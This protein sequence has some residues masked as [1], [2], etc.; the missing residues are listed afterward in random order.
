M[1]LLETSL[2]FLLEGTYWHI[3]FMLTKQNCLRL[4]QMWDTQSIPASET[5]MSI[6]VILMVLVA[7]S[8][9]AGYQL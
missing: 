8:L 2:P 9:W 3:L 6:S 5:L 7:E 1:Q 4:E